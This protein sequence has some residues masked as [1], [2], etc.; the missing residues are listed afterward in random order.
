MAKKNCCK[1][2][3]CC[4]KISFQTKCLLLFS[5]FL[6]IITIGLMILI[7]YNTYSFIYKE[8]SKIYDL[9]EFQ[10]LDNIENDL[11]NI[12]LNIENYFKNNLQSIVNLYKEFSSIKNKKKFFKEEVNNFSLEQFIDNNKE[13]KPKNKIMYFFEESRDKKLEDKEEEI[14][15]SYLGI[16]LN[17]SFSSNDIYNNYTYALFICDYKNK[18]NIFYPGYKSQ[19][20]KDFEQDSIKDY[21]KDKILQ[22]I[23]DFIM[24]KQILNHQIDFYNNIF[25]LPYYDDDNYSV[26]NHLND[27]NEKFFKSE[28]TLKLNNIAFILLPEEDKNANEE[29]GNNVGNNEE[30]E[31]EHKEV[32]NDIINFANFDSVMSSYKGK[33][34]LLIGVNNTE[35]IYIDEI[36]N[37][38]KIENINL[39]R[40]N[41][42]FP[43]ELVGKTCGEDSIDNNGEIK[44][45]LLDECF[46]KTQ[47]L[48]KLKGHSKYKDYT[49]YDPIINDF[50]LY[51]NIMN[52]VENNYDSSLFELY[53]TL[54]KKAIEEK[55]TSFHKSIYNLTLINNDNYK[56]IK[57]YS[58]LHII[59]QTDFFYPIYNIKLHLITLNEKTINDLLEKIK[60]IG[61]DR[62]VLSFLFLLLAA[63]LYLII[64]IILLFYIQEEIRKPMERMNTLNNFYYGQI[65]GDDLRIDEFK[66]IIKSITFELKYDSDYLNS[67]EQKENEGNKMETE[68]F[69]KDFEKNKIFNIF[70]DKE[71][72]NKMLEESNY[73]NEIINNTNLAQIQNDFF[74]KRSALFKECIKMGDFL[75]LDNSEEINGVMNNKIK[76]RDKNT[77]Q[78]PNALFYKNFKKEFDED[79]KEENSEEKND[80]EKNDSEKKIKKEK[81]TEEK[82]DTKKKVQILEAIFM[83]NNKMED[84]NNINNEK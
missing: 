33:I 66:D 2:C 46:D 78:N 29:E 63:F 23:K 48:E 69:N 27:L 19:I 81:K 26:K 25:L 61:E 13:E 56:A 67:G 35:K 40:S 54:E 73:S 68:N 70:V 8:I 60:N 11:E 6:V 1:C 24:L 45:K 34:F 65:T 22:K 53:R 72:I 32:D 74:V 39:F 50:G 21:I 71:R 28:S 36:K 3:K 38:H 59:Y 83:E 51:K 84:E 41:Y 16:Y 64:I 14:M 76:F 17:K 80:S 75:E 62:L 5:V 31:Q 10:E 7:I 79:Y 58:P 55:E 82:S 20:K 30:E 47:K 12:D 52:D 15:L 18:I 44:Y 43:Y 49:S 77:L 37:K 57:V 42:L 4:Q 9:D